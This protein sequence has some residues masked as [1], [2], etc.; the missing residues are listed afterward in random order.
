[1]PS[2]VSTTTRSV[3]IAQHTSAPARCK[4][5]SITGKLC[6]PGQIGVVRM[7]DLRGGDLAQGAVERQAEDLDEE[8]NGVAGEAAYRPAPV[9]VFDVEPWINRQDESAS[10]PVRQLEAAPLEPRPRV[11]MSRAMLALGDEGK[12][13]RKAD[14]PY[15]GCFGTPPFINTHS[16]RCTEHRQRPTASAVFRAVGKP[17]KRLRILAAAAP[18]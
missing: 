13:K 15:R 8:V 11:P 5:H 16:S 18:R 6:V 4:S 7:C 2:K 3:T 10:R 14:I 9:A 1:M 17:L 12:R